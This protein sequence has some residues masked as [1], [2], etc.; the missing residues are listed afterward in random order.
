MLSLSD[1]ILLVKLHYQH[2]ESVTET[3]RAYGS[4]R[5]IKR[6]ALL[7]DWHTVRTIIQKFEEH[8]TVHDFPRSGRSPHASVRQSVAAYV[9]LPL[10][11]STGGLYSL[12]P[13][14]Y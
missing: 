1:R 14:E 8:G 5:G 9:R 10:W 2:G 4:S 13:G 11:L 6:K 12:R 7:P 3:I